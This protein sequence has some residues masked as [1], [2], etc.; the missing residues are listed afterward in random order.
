MNDNNAAIACDATPSVY[1]ITDRSQA[2][3]VLDE[4][5]RTVQNCSKGN[6]Q[7]MVIA[8]RIQCSEEPVNERLSS[9]AAIPK[10]S[11]TTCVDTDSVIE[12][13]Q[14]HFHEVIGQKNCCK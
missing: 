14:N 3:L 13:L 4:L 5:T 1:T 10:P 7:S 11:P 12:K 8:V 6:F 9:D 2:L